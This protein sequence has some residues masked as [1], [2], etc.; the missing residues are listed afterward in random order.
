MYWAGQDEKDLKGPV[1]LAPGW[2]MV[3]GVSLRCKREEAKFR[4]LERSGE[5]RLR[6]S[7]NVGWELESDH[8]FM[9]GYNH[10]FTWKETRIFLN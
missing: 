3:E 9:E 4:F 8:S 7:R 10:I 5:V 2:K 1:A 6:K